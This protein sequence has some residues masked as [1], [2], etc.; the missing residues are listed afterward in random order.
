M[1]FKNGKRAI[2]LK[3]D[4]ETGIVYDTIYYGILF[5]NF[6]RMKAHLEKE[7][8][9]LDSDFD[10]FL[11]LK[12]SVPTPAPELYPFFYNDCSKPTFITTNFCSCF[13]FGADSFSE[14]VQRI[15]DYK[16]EFKNALLP[17]F[18][19]EDPDVLMNSNN[20]QIA[21]EILKQNFD[22]NALT[23]S[24]LNSLF[25]YDAVFDSFLSFICA[26]YK[27]VRKLHAEHSDGIQT[28]IEK[29]STEEFI[30]KLEV[31][32]FIRPSPTLD[33]DKISI[34]L[35]NCLVVMNKENPETGNYYVLGRRC[36]DSLI[37]LPGN[38]K[39]DPRILCEALGHPIKFAIL[40][41]LKEQEFT[42]TQLSEILFASRQ[43]INTHLLWMLKY[44][45]IEIS[46]RD[47]SAIYYRINPCFFRA[48]KNIFFKFADGLTKEDD[49]RILI[50]WYS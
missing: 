7:G 36:E 45:F 30:H 29:Y 44:M 5:F 33:N 15:Q 47:K 49:E 41:K 31:L 26:T 27:S 11:K 12:K 34:C 16:D 10:Y 4:A 3:F 40:R 39:M 17:H 23:V 6:E 14:Y 35:L 18:L 24:L 37:D 19:E 46:R 38:Y 2:V 50:N 22:N 20:E 21:G 8:S 48:A 25:N 13:K 43:A 28:L 32:E 1:E 9:V 42:A